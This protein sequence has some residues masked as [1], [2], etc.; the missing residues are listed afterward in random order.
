MGN[1]TLQALWSQK[2]SLALQRKV[3]G[4]DIV[5]LRENTEDLSGSTV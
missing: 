1:I 2:T 5:I 3:V 4:M